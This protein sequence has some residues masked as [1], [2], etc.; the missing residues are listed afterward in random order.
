MTKQIINVG[1]TDNDGTGSTIRAGGQIINANFTEIYSAIGDG[2]TL[3]FDVSG[4]TAGQSLVYNAATNKFEP[5]SPTATS[6]FIVA[7]DGGSN[8]SIATGNTLNIQGGTGITT[9]GVAT[10]I[11]SVAID[12]TVATLTGNQTLTTKTISGSNNTLSN[13]GNSALTNSSISIGGITLNLGDT[14]ATP[15]LNLIDAT[16][17]PT[18][19]L[20]GSI[21]NNQLVNSTITIVDDSSTASTIDLGS[22]LKIAGSG[23]TTSIS[24]DTLTITG[25]TLSY[26]TG[27]FTG[28]GTTVGF[29]I[30]S[31]RAV[32]DVLVFVNGICLVPTTDY[33]I[34]STT[35]TFQT[36]PAASAEIQVR[37][38]PI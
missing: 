7:G 2:T 37:Y 27:T 12:N 9:T 38:L 26:S 17:Y 15:A 6:T 8:Q 24:G 25:A 28:D 18:S 36:A 29:T 13:I 5:G 23:V 10:D 11:L 20:T 34:A 33:T 22:T 35:L 1:T 14:D 16:N 32:N 31:G 21:T 30:N 3:A 19:S 4:A